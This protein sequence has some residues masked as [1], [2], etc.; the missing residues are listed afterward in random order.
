MLTFCFSK[1]KFTIEKVL[2]NLFR[3]SDNLSTLV[4]SVYT[5]SYIKRIKILLKRYG[6]LIY[7]LCFIVVN[8]QISRQFNR[9][10][11][12]VLQYITL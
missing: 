5:H 6:I 10:T 8:I 2:P 9:Q 12:C 7:S 11:G 1:F 3:M 4:Y